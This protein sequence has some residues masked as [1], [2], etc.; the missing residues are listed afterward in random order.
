MPYFK[1]L[2]QNFDSIIIYYI[3]KSFYYFIFFK[4]IKNKSIT[5]SKIINIYIIN[6][7]N[8]K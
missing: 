7:I 2:N 1:F 3:T 5:I 6:N 8:I 4:S